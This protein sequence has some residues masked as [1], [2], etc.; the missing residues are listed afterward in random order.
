MKAVRYVRVSSKEQE[1][2]Y[3][4]DAQ[5]REGVR[6]AAQNGLEI[7]KSWRVSESAWKEERT[8]FNEMIA[9]VKKHPDVKVI[10]FDS[11]DRMTRNLWDVH[12]IQKLV[13]QY[14]KEIHFSRS[15]KVLSKSS[16]PDDSFMLGIEALTAKKYSDDISFKVKR[17]MRQK[18]EQGEFP[19][20][21]PFGYRNNKEAK[22]VELDPEGGRWVK[23]A[24]ELYASG[25]FSLDTLRLKLK[26]EGFPRK[27]LHKSAL[28]QM[29]KNPFYYGWFRWQGQLYKGAYEPLL[30]KSLYD[31]VQRAFERQ[32]KPKGR[33][34]NFPYT[35]LACC[36]RCG[37]A[38]TAE[39]K[40]GQY[41][42]YH[43]TWR[44]GR[45]GN[46]YVR[47]D[48]LEALFKDELERV[49]ID[50]EVI[51]QIIGRLQTEL[52]LDLSAHQ[53][54]IVA[55]KAQH[56]R[57]KDRIEKAYADRLDDKISENFWR[58]QTNK[59]NDELA[60][61][62]GAI[63]QHQAADPGDR[64]VTIERLLELANRLPDI[65]LQNPPEKRRLILNSVCSNF[66][67]IDATLTPTWKQPFDLLAKGLSS[68]EWLPGCNSIRSASAEARA[69]R[70]GRSGWA[71]P[72]IY[73]RIVHIALDARN[74]GPV[75]AYREQ[76]IE[77]AL[78]PKGAFEN[79]NI[80]TL[81]RRLP[82]DRVVSAVPPPRG[83][84]KPPKVP[85]T[86]RV[87][88]FLRKAIEWQTLLASGEAKNQADIAKREGISRVRVCQVMWLLRL[89][90]EIQQHVLSMSETI[91][92]P[93]ITERA[94]RP[95]AQ[96]ENITEQHT[97]FQTLLGD[98]A[99]A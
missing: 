18:A 34:R 4:L 88:E 26:T 5:E 45:C 52:K 17:A 29:L 58:E 86:P 73:F 50:R 43:C 38:I 31:E 54:T 12:K 84:P 41:V 85:R 83:K 71:E 11:V 13:Q 81:T 93:A 19:Q 55:L 89:A 8:A 64:L 10:I 66:A 24:F 47:Q 51:E 39:E 80:G 36:G 79:G 77:I 37:C 94:L 42:Y 33:R 9:Y 49:R 61:V 59:W 98:S 15:G 82:A 97:R 30:P 44:R 48:R 23:Q 20:R 22:K 68:K 27:A 28:E 46:G 21:A 90:P 91:R 2:G 7:V 3:S 65:F 60:S 14:D 16:P 25:N 53:E 95:I 63:T 74:G 72:E 99:P 76:T 1:D 69:G 70:R 40:K 96:V 32:N 78:G 92:R 57:L 62:E 87:V 6:H 35:G 67:L 75:A 56:R